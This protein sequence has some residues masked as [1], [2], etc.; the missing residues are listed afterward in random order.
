MPASKE[1]PE[2]RNSNMGVYARYS[3]IALQ[4]GV[5]IAGSTIGGFKLDQWL[6]LHFP[7]F[8]VVLSLLGVGLAIYLL[9][10]TVSKSGGK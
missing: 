6:N 5:V 10:R 4:M 2:G 9:I 7:I 8:T 1:K 3:A